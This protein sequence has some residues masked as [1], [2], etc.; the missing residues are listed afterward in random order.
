M[1]VFLMGTLTFPPSSPSEESISELGAA[2]IW[3]DCGELDLASSLSSPL[4][5]ADSIQT[6]SAKLGF[7]NGC[8]FGRLSFLEC[9][10]WRGEVSD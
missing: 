6:D 8:G 1:V 4:F 9:V 5:E 2:F 3:T 7:W 10:F